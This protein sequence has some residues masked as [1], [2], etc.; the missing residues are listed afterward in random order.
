[1]KKTLVIFL[2]M[3][4]LKIM[5]AE[6]MDLDPLHL[7]GSYSCTGYDSNDGPYHNE[8]SPQLTLTY[9][10]SHSIPERQMASY[11]FKL[12]V[13]DG[14][15]FTGIAALNGSALAIYFAN[16]D[17]LKWDDKGIGAAQI[18][19]E[20][21]GVDA[22]NEPEYKTIFSKFYYEPIYSKTGGHGVEVCIKNSKD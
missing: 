14:S 9:I 22:R 12:T 6:A 19:R 4:S 8:P 3:I 7:Q 18:I 20:Y 21:I 15:L 13:P 10:K 5:N 2:A 1:M 16:N 11:E 17:P